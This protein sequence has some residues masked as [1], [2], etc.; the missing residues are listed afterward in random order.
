MSAPQALTARGS[1]G[2]RIAPATA[3]ARLAPD[4]PDPLGTLSQARPRRPSPANP[5]SPAPR[6]APAPEEP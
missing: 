4:A 2:S 5:A 3:L 1:G 6:P